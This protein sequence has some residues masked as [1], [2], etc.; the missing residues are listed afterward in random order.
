MVDAKGEQV[1]KSKAGK[2]WECAKN[3]CQ[4]QGRDEAAQ[5]EETKQGDEQ[6]GGV[7][8][9][10][11]REQEQPEEEEGPVEEEEEENEEEEEVMVDNARKE[12]EEDEA[13]DSEPDVEEGL[14]D[15]VEGT[16]RLKR[17]LSRETD[18]PGVETRA[19]RR[20]TDMGH[21]SAAENA[22][23]SQLLH[24]W[25]LAHDA[26]T[27][28]V[29][30]NLTLGELD[31]LIESNYA[32]E[33][34]NIWKCPAELLQIHT[35]LLRE[36]KGPGGGPLDIVSCFRHRKG[37]DAVAEKLLRTLKHKELRY[38]IRE[39]DGSVPLEEVIAAAAD[40]DPELEGIGVAA[41]PEA[42]GVQAMSRYTRLELID[43]L[44]DCAVFGDANLTFSLNLAR[45]RKALG[46]VG[47]VVATTFET[48]E[49]LQERYKEI[50]G[51]IKKLEEHFAEVYHG[52]DCTRI[53]IDPRFTGMANSLGAVYYNF[54]H[55]GAVGGFFDGHPVVNWRHENLMRLFF[56][57]LRSFVKP[58]AIVKVAS[59]SGA[60]GVRFSFIVSSAIQNE[61][62]H[63]ETMAFLQWQLHRYGRSYGDR[64]DTYKR[65]GEGEQYN[66]QRAESDMVYCFVYR[67]SGK[68]LPRQQIRLPPTYKTML[69]C[70][71]GALGERQGEEKK[72]YATE[73]YKRFIEEFSGRHVG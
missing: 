66:A 50:T 17:L 23:V 19:K 38:V 71:D 49:T 26:L 16:L 27:K 20:K 59:N 6:D 39:Y 60:V 62:E 43:P 64:R 63:E 21:R 55:A 41:A 69:G 10:E 14:K 72:R 28:H 22:K 40:A 57:A 45:Q 1:G 32:P 47:R 7:E 3:Q 30:D 36:S 58:G 65:P 12:E 4:T 34:N 8:Q 42:P 37:L 68:V 29:L 25:V 2:E 56:R 48:L 31:H 53:A 24:K 67:P 35:N 5:Q 73:L 33:Q 9:D 15:A 51:T 18:L 54:P 13:E 61:F 46:H 44:A 11:P 52:V 70:S